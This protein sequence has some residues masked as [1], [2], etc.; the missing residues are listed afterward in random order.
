MKYSVLRWKYHRDLELPKESPLV[1]G[2]YSKMTEMSVEV[3]LQIAPTSNEDQ[4]LAVTP[5]SSQS[6]ASD[7]SRQLSSATGVPKAQNLRLW[8]TTPGFTKQTS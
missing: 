3:T 2:N 6:R 5:K 1:F 8:M 7:L 4:C